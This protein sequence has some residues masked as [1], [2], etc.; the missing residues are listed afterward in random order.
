MVNTKEQTSTTFSE[1]ALYAGLSLAAIGLGIEL[2]QAPITLP[3]KLVGATMI[4]YGAN[5]LVDQF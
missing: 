1:R 5:T 4:A 3:L 2:L